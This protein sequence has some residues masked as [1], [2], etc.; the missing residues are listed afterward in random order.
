LISD[1]SR[2]Q[3]LFTSNICYMYYQE[4]EK[5]AQKP[6]GVSIQSYQKA[7]IWGNV[8]AKDYLNKAHTKQIKC[9]TQ[10]KLLSAKTNKSATQSVSQCAYEIKFCVRSATR[11]SATVCDC[12]NGK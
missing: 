5:L 11:L 12:T 3:F 4:S 1:L 6:S 7:P 2:F 9:G 8:A 10:N